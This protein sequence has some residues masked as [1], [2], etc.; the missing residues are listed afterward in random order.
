[1]TTELDSLTREIKLMLRTA[2]DIASVKDTHIGTDENARELRLVTDNGVKYEL[3]II[4][5]GDA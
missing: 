3:V 1:M 5:C 2:P 4:Q